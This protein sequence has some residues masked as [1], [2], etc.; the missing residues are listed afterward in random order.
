MKNNVTCKWWHFGVFC[1]E[2]KRKQE[3]VENLKFHYG[4]ISRRNMISMDDFPKTASYSEALLEENMN[5]FPS[6]TENAFYRLEKEVSWLNEIIQ[7]DESE[8]SFDDDYSSDQCDQLN[9]FC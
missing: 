5:E 4:K 2:V 8:F 9:N 3:F 6:Y 1:D 7:N